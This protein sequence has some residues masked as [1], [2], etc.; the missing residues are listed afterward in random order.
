MDF[1]P[2]I[3]NIGAWNLLLGRKVNV[4]PKAEK[5]NRIIIDCIPIIYVR[6]VPY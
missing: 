4:A 2:K 6:F 3:I 1:V 5:S